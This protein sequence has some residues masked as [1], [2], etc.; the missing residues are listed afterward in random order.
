RWLCRDRADAAQRNQPDGCGGRSVPAPRTEFG[1][2]P[3]PPAPSPK[4]RGG[5]ELVFLPL[6]ASG[7]GRGGGVVSTGPVVRGARRGD[8]V[9]GGDALVRGRDAGQRPG[10]A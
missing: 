9:P 5:A 4:R 7:R 6:S 2:N 1:P 8:R 10:A 3:L